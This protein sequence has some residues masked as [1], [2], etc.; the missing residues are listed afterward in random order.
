M[1]QP[2]A[3][4]RTVLAL[5]MAVFIPIQLMAQQS[6]PVPAR[7]RIPETLPPTTEEWAAPDVSPRPAMSNWD[8]Y[9]GRVY[10]NTSPVWVQAEYLLWWLQGHELPPLVTASTAGTPRPEAGVLGQ[11]HTQVLFGDGR[12][13]DDARSGFRTTLGVRLGHWFDALMESELQFDYLWLGDGQSS[14]DYYSDSGEHAILARPFFNTQLDQQDAELVSYPGVVAGGIEVETSSDLSSAGVMFRQGWLAGSRGRLEWLAGYR[15]LQLQEELGVHETLVITDPGGDV[16]VGTTF[17]LLDEMSTW[18]E[19]HGGDLGVQWWTHARGWTFE[20]VT[21]L[22]IGGIARTVQIDGDT[23]VQ[24][25]DDPAVLTPGGLLAQPTN[26]G[27]HRTG[28]FTAVPELSI[29]VRRQLTHHLILTAGYSLVIVDHVVRTGDQLDL[30]VNPT[31]FGGGELSGVP[32]PGV[33]M[34]DSTL[35]LHGLS[36]GLEW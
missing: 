24:T 4:V 5:V 11:P 8:L 28:R 36:V 18:N 9:A 33:L 17:D 34:H 6:E 20:F 13:D 22:A 25:P 16:P 29:K 21:K 19:F 12:V 14:D 35:W 2:S 3:P 30:V 7:A 32:R 15:Y 10:A 23:L 31:Q 26:I 27:R 1:T